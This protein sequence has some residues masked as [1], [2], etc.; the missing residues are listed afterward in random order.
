MKRRLNEIG[1][2]VFSS[3]AL[4]VTGNYVYDYVKDVPILGFIVRLF[5]SLYELITGT[6]N[7]PEKIGSALVTMLAIYGFISLIQLLLR[8]KK[9]EFIYYKQDRFRVWI[10]KWDWQLIEGIWQI[11]NLRAHCPA[12]EVELVETGNLESP[13][14]K[15]PSND[16]FYNNYDEPKEEIIR[17]IQKKVDKNEYSGRK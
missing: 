5:K 17:L 11:V 3:I 16:R 12:C 1:W 6:T 13:C 7:W 10:W 14:I 4:G 8:R 15:C 2:T 9:P